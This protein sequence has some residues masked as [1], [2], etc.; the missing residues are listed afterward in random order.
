M[1]ASRW[2]PSASSPQMAEPCSEALSLL[3]DV[4]G[5]GGVRARKRLLLGAAACLPLAE[6]AGLL[7][8]ADREALAWLRERSLVRH[9]AGRPVVLWLDVI[10]AI[11]AEGGGAP[12]VGRADTP[13]ATEK[14]PPRLQLAPPRARRPP[15]A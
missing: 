4:A 9:L 15:P 6:A 10:E 13:T 8:L 1:T 14:S 11:R 5:T 12:S 2:I 3:A 7:P